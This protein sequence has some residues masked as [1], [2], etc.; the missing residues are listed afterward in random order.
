MKQL[1]KL[2]YRSSLGLFE[3]RLWTDSKIVQRLGPPGTLST[4]EVVEQTCLQIITNF[5]SSYR[6]R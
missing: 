4:E 6:E 2:V 5:G 1:N 3:F